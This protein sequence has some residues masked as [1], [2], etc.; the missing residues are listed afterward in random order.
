MINPFILRQQQLNKQFYKPEYDMIKSNVDFIVNKIEKANKRESY[1]V[2]GADAFKFDSLLAEFKNSLELILQNEMGTLLKT[3]FVAIEKAYNK[4]ISYLNNVIKYNDLNYNDKQKYQNKLN[5]IL[6]LVNICLNTVS[7]K[8]DYELQN[9]KSFDE[10]LLKK[11]YQNLDNNNYQLISYNISDI[12]NIKTNVSYPQQ[13]KIIKNY[14]TKMGNIINKVDNIV[15]L[16]PNDE[17]RLLYSELRGIY[18]E[19]LVLEYNFEKEK[20]IEL[21]E[22]ILI[23]IMNKM[24]VFDQYYKSIKVLEVVEPAVPEPAVPEPAVPEPAVP[25]P[26]VPE[27]KKRGRPPKDKGKVGEGR[28]RRKHKKK[29]IKKSDWDLE[30]E[31]Q[32]GFGK[33]KHKL[34]SNLKIKIK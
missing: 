23:D 5:E 20:D 2:V 4:M 10:N 15:E 30:E 1:E 19:F 34:S 29:I 14:K 25:E 13:L 16:Y 24:T 33:R 27:Q 26:A 7:I 9:Y 32:L 17:N 22:N 18:D 21:R 28:R 12:E 11:I 31:E 3:N 8:N 6:P